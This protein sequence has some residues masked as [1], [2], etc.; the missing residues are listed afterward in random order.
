MAVGTGGALVVLTLGP[1]V[2]VEVGRKGGAHVTQHFPLLDWNL[3]RATAGLE[4]VCDLRLGCQ[5]LSVQPDSCCV[6]A[7]CH[8]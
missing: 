7:A 5:R 6:G 4:A 1:S 8:P 3:G 2:L